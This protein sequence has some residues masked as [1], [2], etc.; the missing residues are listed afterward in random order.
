MAESDNRPS[1]LTA[2]AFSG[3]R[4]GSRSPARMPGYKAARVRGRWHHERVHPFPA[5]ESAD[6]PQQGSQEGRAGTGSPLSLRALKS[7]F[8]VVVLA[9]PAILVGA[10]WEP[11]AAAPMIL[12]ALVGVA[13]VIPGGPRLGFG[14]TALLLLLTPVAV[15]SGSVP[16][17]GACVVALL[18]MASG[19]TAL[20]GLESALVM[21]PLVMAYF[22]IEP[23]SLTGAPVDRLAESYLIPAMLL[24]AGGS[25]WLVV[26]VPL[27]ARQRDLPTLQPAP[28]RD[29]AV[30]TVAITVLCAGS[31][32]AV[33]TWAPGTR[34]AWLVLTI[35]VVA[36]LGEHT[37][38]QRS[39]H[40]VIGTIIGALLAAAAAEVVPSVGGEIAL[41]LLFLAVAM[42]A[43]SGPRYWVY[44]TFLTPAV[45]LLSSPGQ[46]L[47][48]GEQRVIFTVIGAGLVLL[49]AGVVFGFAHLRR[50]GRFFAG[51]ISS[52]VDLS[53]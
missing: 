28:R 24:V 37:T 10:L 41:A 35:L 8:L 51:P 36:K 31:T 38:V 3:D 53:V 2:F 40:R 49:T 33:M 9:L 42:T 44:V 11:K 27:L 16:L 4:D 13:T 22:V 30:Y 1:C 29:T 7:V 52:E 21:I 50:S 26:L 5:A 15:V 39:V 46:V 32:F 47:L 12:G 45:V 48:G 23:V 14:V 20:W 6:E 34:G 43:R 17:A 19:V 25:L 18:C